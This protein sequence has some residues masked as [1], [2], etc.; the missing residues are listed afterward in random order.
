MDHSL[1]FIGYEFSTGNGTS[2]HPEAFPPQTVTFEHRFRGGASETSGRNRGD[3]YFWKT[4]R[5][6]YR[7]GTTSQ[8]SC[9]VLFYF[10]F[11]S[12]ISSISLLSI[13]VSLDWLKCGKISETPGCFCHGFYHQMEEVPPWFL[14]SISL[15]LQ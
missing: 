1:A 15:L 14:L 7:V 9:F 2:V 8:V 10:F 12:S 13:L 6:I 5:Q 11:R 4:F 3:R